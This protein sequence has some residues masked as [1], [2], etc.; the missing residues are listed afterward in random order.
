VRALR[1][2]VCAG[3][4]ALR[5]LFEQPDAFELVRAQAFT[6]WPRVGCA[7]RRAV[8]GSTCG[9]LTWPLP[10]SPPVAVALTQVHLNDLGA[11]ESTAYLIKYDSVHGTWAHGSSAD[12]DG[13]TIVLSD[14]SRAGRALRVPYSRAKEPA[15]LAEA[16]K[17]AGVAMVLECT[18]VFLTRAAL[19]PYFDACGV[20]KVVVSAPVKDPVPV[21]NVVVGVNSALYD[22]AVDHIVT[23]ASCTTNCLAPVVKARARVTRTQRAACARAALVLGLAAGLL[24]RASREEGL[25]RY[26]QPQTHRHNVHNVL[27]RTGCTHRCRTRAAATR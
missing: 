1:A 21:L 12:A 13:N 27:T 18:G 11:C 17:A 9:N 20:R 10:L 7:A 6:C 23:A 15:A 14:T 5:V 8:A 25:T 2:C 24:P 19:A 22:P 26:K 4:L 16:Y 3:R